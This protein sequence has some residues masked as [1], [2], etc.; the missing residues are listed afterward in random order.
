MTEN[1]VV[2]GGG[3]GVAAILR[4]IKN[5]EGFHISAIITVADD[6]GSTGRLRARYNIPAVGDIRNVLTALAESESLLS[7]LMD[8]RFGGDSSISDDIAG[9]SLGNLILV[10]LMQSSGNIMEAIGQVGSVLRIRGEIIPSTTEVVDLFAE[11]KDGTIV[12]GEDSI[13]SFKNVIKRVFYDREVL[14]TKE[15]VNALTEADYIVLGIGSLYTSVIPNLI[16]KG[17]S[18]AI[19]NNKK[20]K[21]IYLCNIMTEPGETDNY[22]VDD[23]IRA[24]EDHMK[25]KIDTVIYP[26]NTIPEYIINKYKTEGSDVV[27][28]DESKKRDCKIIKSDLLCFDEDQARHCSHKIEQA[29]KTRMK[30]EF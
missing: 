9:H 23:H 20:A 26:S 17:I 5:I 14:A 18:E 8:Y 25:G 2:I 22:D 28:L 11:M 1:I 13:P 6:G 21:V 10:A 4:G 27:I 12:R 7:N 3:T 16:V 30:V 19:N 29:I 15:A 24:I